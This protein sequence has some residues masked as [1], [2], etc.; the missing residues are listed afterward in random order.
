MSFS[1]VN[2]QYEDSLESDPALVKK[3][4]EEDRNK[5][6]QHLA[7][8]QMISSPW[9][10]CKQRKPLRVFPRW[11]TRRGRPQSM[12]TWVPATLSLTS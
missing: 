1:S 10:D 12:W 4:I 2:T 5:K 8:A 3:K 9:S 7:A 11:N 6:G